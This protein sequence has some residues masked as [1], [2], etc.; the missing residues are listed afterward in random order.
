MEAIPKV[1]D[2]Q[3]AVD[4]TIALADGTRLEASIGW[5]DLVNGGVMLDVVRIRGA[6]RDG[7]QIALP[8]ALG[9]DAAQPREGDR[10]WLPGHRIAALVFPAPPSRRR[11]VGF[12]AG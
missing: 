12:A 8:E 7:R 10:V 11:P 1:E 3:A 5:D 4:V 9:L 6:S 2:R